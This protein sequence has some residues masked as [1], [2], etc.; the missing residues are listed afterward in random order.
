MLSKSVSFSHTFQTMCLDCHKILTKRKL[1]AKVRRNTKEI[2]HEQSIMLKTKRF[3]YWGTFF[4]WRIAGHVIYYLNRVD[5][6]FIMHI[7]LF[8]WQVLRC[9]RHA[10]E[11]QIRIQS[12]RHSPIWSKRFLPGLVASQLSGEIESISSCHFTREVGKLKYDTPTENSNG[13][14]KPMTRQLAFWHR[15]K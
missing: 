7:S 12:S 15:L 5:L 8:H 10:Y 9:S 1:W 14:R 4:F 11:H 3:G 13:G 2:L 6:S